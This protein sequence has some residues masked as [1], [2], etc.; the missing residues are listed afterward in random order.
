MV[1]HIKV[2]GFLGVARALIALALGV[3][4]LVKAERL[5][6]RDY[7]TT[8]FALDAPHTEARHGEHLKFDRVAFRVVGAA[9]LLLA[10]LRLA[11][12]VASLRTCRWARFAGVCLAGFDI[13]NL[14]LFPLSTTLGLYGLVVWRHPECEQRFKSRSSVSGRG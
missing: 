8:R 1:E 9:C 2:L 3:V 14:A 5:D 4:L 10:A 13:A 7:E 11:Q 6:L 12:G